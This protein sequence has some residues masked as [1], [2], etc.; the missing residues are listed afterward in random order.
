MTTLEQKLADLNLGWKGSRHAF[1]IVHK[2]FGLALH[3]YEL[4]WFSRDVT[5]KHIKTYNPRQGEFEYSRGMG[6]YYPEEE[7]FRCPATADF[8]AHVI[9]Q[10]YPGIF[11]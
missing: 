1:C 5:M 2:G 8:V 10:A 6:N 4:I 9:E 7:M 3:K 11:D